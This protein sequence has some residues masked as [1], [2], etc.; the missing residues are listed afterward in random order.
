MS[1]AKTLMGVEFQYSGSLATGLT[2]HKK[3]DIHISPAIIKTIKDEISMGF[4]L[5]TTVIK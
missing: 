2:I 5:N 3:V 4:F 1:N